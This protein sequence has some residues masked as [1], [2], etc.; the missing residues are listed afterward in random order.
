MSVL[1]M[2]LEHFHNKKLPIQTTDTLVGHPI[3]KDNKTS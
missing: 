2:R 1:E 3:Q